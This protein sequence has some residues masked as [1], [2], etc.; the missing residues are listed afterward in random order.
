MLPATYEQSSDWQF[1]CEV[2]QYAFSE[3]RDLPACELCNGTGVV[4]SDEPLICAACEGSGKILGSSTRTAAGRLAELSSPDV[5]VTAVDLDVAV[6]KQLRR[7][8]FL[9]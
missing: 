5:V 3:I 4:E 6:A 1:L 8:D 2:G 7:D 9:A